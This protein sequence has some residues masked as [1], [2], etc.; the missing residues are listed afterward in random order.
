MFLGDYSPGD[1]IDFLFTTHAA[2]GA[3]TVLSGSP[4]C[5]VYKDNSDTQ[6]TS[7]LTLTASADSVTGMN[8]VRITT[9]TSTSFY[10]NGQFSVVI[11]TG[12][13]DSVSVVGY[14]VGRFRLVSRSDTGWRGR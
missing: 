12:T 3:P 11:T 9:A 1:A 2:T 10:T 8:R 4:V 7:G 6:S 5:S 14:V 13:V